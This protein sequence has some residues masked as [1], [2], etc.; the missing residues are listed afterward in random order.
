MNHFLT[1]IFEIYNQSKSKIEFPWNWDE[2]ENTYEQEPELFE[3][4]F[5]R[6]SLSRYDF[7][8]ELLAN[9]LWIALNVTDSYLKRSQCY[10]CGSIFKLTDYFSGAV[11]ID[12]FNPISKTGQHLAGNI[13]P[14]CKDCNLLKSNLSDE[15]F[16]II[17][18]MP[19]KFFSN[20]YIKSRE[21]KKEKLKDFSAII[22]QRLVS[23][24]EYRQA[25]NITIYDQRRHQ[26]DLK[27]SYRMKWLNN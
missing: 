10:Y 26:D 19:E 22:F 4:I 18:R 1:K 23:G 5:K 24:E 2:I 25:F 11:H 6:S 20:R 21:M 15:D 12:H 9:S 14:T 13:V 16:L 8:E 7:Q 3:N 27:A 17:F